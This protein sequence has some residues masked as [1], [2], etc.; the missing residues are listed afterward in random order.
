MAHS[1]A[2]ARRPG[3]LPSRRDRKRRHG[4]VTVTRGAAGG[5]SGRVLRSHTGLITIPLNGPERWLWLWRGMSIVA[6]AALG[7]LYVGWRYSDQILAWFE[8][9][10]G[11]A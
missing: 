6:A 3:G 11:F 8:Q 5:P 1:Y 10:L 7:G 9:A 4:R 2:R